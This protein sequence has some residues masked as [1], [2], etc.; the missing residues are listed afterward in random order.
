M[1][2]NA[3][4]P[5]PKFDSHVSKSANRVTSLLSYRAFELTQVNTSSPLFADYVLY[6]AKVTVLSR[7]ACSPVS[8]CLFSNIFLSSHLMRS[9]PGPGMCA[10]TLSYPFSTK[11]RKRRLLQWLHTGRNH[12]C[13]W[14]NSFSCHISMLLFSR[15]QVW[16]FFLC[17]QV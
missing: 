1:P 12:T 2:K 11:A 13:E 15:K 4:E 8:H 10:P 16:V 5:S 3:I 9:S 17:F 14:R 7:S 6:V